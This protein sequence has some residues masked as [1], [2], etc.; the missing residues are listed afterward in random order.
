MK[1][2][3]L[4]V[5][6]IFILGLAVLV[7]R[8]P[9]ISDTLKGRLIPEL[10]EIT[11][12]KVAVETIALNLFPLFLEAKG[13][14]LLD[15]QGS[16]LIK[17]VRA[18]AYI[19]LG[20]IFSKRITLYRLV[21]YD[22]EISIRRQK[23]EEII[24]HVRTYLQKEKTKDFEVKV[25]VIEVKKGTVLVR[26]EPAQSLLA[27]E[28]LSGE[29]IGG[30]R[31]RL[32]AEVQKVIFKKASWP[33]IVCDVRTTLTFRGE[34]IAIKKLEIGAYGSTF[35]GEGTYGAGKGVLKTNLALLMKSVKRLFGLTERDEGR[36][37]ATGEVQIA[38]VGQKEVSIRS[39]Q[40][41]L[42][43]PE[44][45]NIL[46]DL[47]LSGEFYLETLMELLRVKDQLEGL[48]KV[49]GEL[50]GPLSD[51]SGTAQ[52]KLKQGN[53]YGV[54]IDSLV[55]DISY[56]DR[57]MKFENGSASL[58]NGKGQAEALIHLPVV[59][60]YS[61]RVN[62]QSVDSLPLFGLIKWDPEIPDGKVDGELATSGNRFN[63][64]GAFFYRAA[65]VGKQAY[66][67]GKP[68]PVENVISRIR[69]LKGRFTKRDQIISLTDLQINTSVSHL[70]LNGA[71]DLEKKTLNLR[72]R[73]IAET[74]GDLSA[75]YYMGL[76]G[77]TEFS[78]EIAGPLEDPRITGRAMLANADL[79]GYQIDSIVSDISYEKALLSTRETVFRSPGQEHVVRGKISFLGPKHLFDVSS[80][81]Y[82]LKAVL[83]NADFGKVIRMFY[84]EFIGQGRMH[85]DLA[86][87]GKGRGFLLSGKG[88]MERG[89]LYSVPFD[90]GY[91][92]FSYTHD[93]LSLKTVKIAKNTS[94]LRAEGIIGGDGTFSYHA[95]ADKL[96]LKDLGLQK[97][98]DDA[99]ISLKSEGTGTFDNPVVTFDAKVIGGTFKGKDMGRG[100][101]TGSIRNRDIFVQGALFNEKMRLS[102]KGRLDERLPWS[103]ELAIQPARYDFI[104]SSILKDVP[105]DLELFLEG[106][107]TLQGDRHDIAVNTVLQRLTLSLFGQTLSN[108][109][110]ISFALRNRALSI[111]A[112]TVTSGTASFRLSGDVEI[113]KSY[114]LSLEG[115]SALS[116]LQGMSKKIGYLR[117]DA[118]FSLSVNGPWDDPDITGGMN[119]TDASFG[120]RGYP[121]YIS[122]LHGRLFMDEDR[123]V[124]QKLTGKIGGGNVT[125]SGY[126]TLKA[127]KAKRFYVEAAVENV[128][129][130]P[131]GNFSINF[132]G[133][134]LLKGTPEQQNI[135]GDIRINR[136]YYKENIEWRSWI[137]QA[138]TKE[139]PR[140]ETTL[141][142]HTELNI[143][144]TGSDKISV[145]NNIA[146]APV[147]IRGDMI[148]KGT[149]LHP[150]LFGRVEANEGYVYFRNNE[151]KIIHASADFADPN[152]IKPVFNFTAET[153]VSGYN[154][155]LTLEGQP[156]HFT[157]ALTSDPHL[158]EVD[159]LAL[160]T[161]GRV[162]SQ[163]KGIE[164]GVGAGEATS[165]VTGPVGDVIE[166]RM[167][168]ITGIDRFQIEPTVSE[169]SGTVSPRVIVS[170]RLI[171]DKLYVTYSNLVGSTEEQIIK[172][173]YLVSRN[174]SLIGVHDERRGVGGDI[175]FR[176]EFK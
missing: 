103:A 81:V 141:F 94:I 112:C 93:T 144:I 16:A 120:L 165:F 7:P 158:D 13:I 86:M 168:S 127:F 54:D 82:D 23:L 44:L 77:R 20:G 33:K 133:N 30:E 106:N 45:K 119:I 164:G 32:S 138:K 167:R 175:K 35:T 118:D 116:P 122:S 51:I 126:V 5:L 48:V 84:K 156:D 109:S 73:V 117:G 31:Q 11:G 172:I 72:G 2:I 39:E 22:P 58:Y 150:V 92:D 88:R 50:R 130:S 55:C 47:K 176:F 83:K 145:D 4:S 148:L 69:D 25:N 113:G 9:Q 149:L 124:L 99:I 56:K 151:F 163:M 171:A 114:N 34:N 169:T 98:P 49:Q 110:P 67:S 78:G 36:I 105:E 68:Y 85:A 137:F 123:I 162:G 59:D 166:E 8:I 26:D 63:P 28:G 134:L 14:R 40:Q 100:H 125:A 170:K 87:T 3:I 155:R 6:L 102:G 42:P 79:E 142:E 10:E 43:V 53:L 139:V 46:L 74:A 52:A 60:F 128:T 71:V 153:S 108:D 17:T 152:R 143:R 41:G 21:F 38:P 96:F 121:T 101:I 12:E 129:T 57:V 18:K 146:R 37:S 135:I 64:E 174:V 90:S 15:E 161:V 157:L 70:I 107:V 65:L 160:L 1:K 115:K 111:T 29:F 91:S 154:I 62:V 132:G 27:I 19:D 131:S 24:H 75:P 80:P 66:Y 97:M 140:A 89:S 61:L 95:S 104:L 76:Q 173:E 147:R 159:I 136:A